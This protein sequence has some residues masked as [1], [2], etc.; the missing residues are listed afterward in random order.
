MLTLLDSIFRRYFYNFLNINNSYPPDLWEAL[1]RIL[2]RLSLSYQKNNIF[3]GGKRTA[4]SG[5]N[6]SYLAILFSILYVFSGFYLVQPAE[7]A[8]VLFL[9][10]YN[11]MKESGLHWSPT[12]ITSIHKEN[13]EKLR[14]VRLEKEMLTSEENIVHVSFTIQYKIGD[15]KHYLYSTADPIPLLQQS[16]ESTVRQVVGENKLEKILTTSRSQ[17]T[18][19]IEVELNRL[20]SDYNT[21]IWISEVIMQPARAPSGVKSAFDDVIKA[22]EDR[23]R[24]QN[25]AESYS[26]KVIPRAKGQA[27]RIL[28]EARAY[29]EKIVMEAQGNISGFDSLLDLYNRNNHIVKSQMY[30]EA[31][32]TIFKNNKLYFVEN[33]GNKN[34]FQEDRSPIIMTSQEGKNNAF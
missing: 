9:G 8:T 21:G 11:G 32:A 15:L 4:S 20:L 23:E 5:R 18:Q 26:N 29:K 17:I 30:Y 10:Q 1:L 19:K 2:S 16:L 34:I 12:F 27:Q 13:V 28:D 7:K 33:E 3:F 24:L 25:E 22:R 31:I 6:L 14:T